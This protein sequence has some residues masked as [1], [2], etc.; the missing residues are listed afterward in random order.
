M[1]RPSNAADLREALSTTNG[2]F[3][4]P[5]HGP[6]MDMACPQERSE[7]PFIARVQFAVGVAGAGIVS[8]GSRR[9]Q[10]AQLTTDTPMSSPAEQTCQLTSKNHYLDMYPSLNALYS[11]VV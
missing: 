11:R 7:H 8:N 9:G 10:A 3:F 5:S 1:C 6:G 2:L 4:A